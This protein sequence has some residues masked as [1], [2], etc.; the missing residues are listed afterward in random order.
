MDPHETLGA[1][2]A[3]IVRLFPELGGARLTLLT[4]G[5]DSIAVDVDDRL[6]FKFPRHARAEAAL[7]REWA[8][9]T[10]LRPRLTMP[11]PDMALH[12]GPPLMSRHVKLAGDHLVPDGYRRLGEDARQD[13]AAC[14][15][16]FYAELHAI[17]PEVVARAGAGP[18]QPLMPAE[19][20]ASRALP[21]LHAGLRAFAEDTLAAWAALPP[22]PHGEVYGFFDGHGWNMAFDPARGRLN[23][24]YDFGDSGFGEL[25]GE[26]ISSNFIDPDLTLR[27]IASY[28]S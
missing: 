10:A 17:E 27:I 18:I 6:I 19:E 20:I 1:C 8:L 12:A 7:K 25:S 26:F 11:V 5:W 22:D 15:A 16:R 28:N 14:L 13:L 21:L 2:R 9:L 3:A 23:G 4:A 24:I